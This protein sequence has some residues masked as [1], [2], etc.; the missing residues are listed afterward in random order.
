MKKLYF[1]L[2]IC[3][4][5]LTA[6]ADHI[7]GGDMYYSYVGTVNGLHQYSVT[8]RLYMRC[9]SGRNFND[10]T[11]VS[12]FERGTNKRERDMYVKVSKVENIKLPSNSDPCVTNPPFVC[13]EVGYYIF[14]V[15]LPSSANGY[16]LASQVNYRIAGINNL[17]PGYGLIGATYTTEIPGL[18]QAA[19]GPQNNSANFIGTD[20]VMVCAEN[21]FSYSFAAVDKDNDELRYSFCGAYV[22]GNSNTVSA[23]PPPP[24]QMV[25]YGS[26]YSESTPLGSEV[27]IDPNTGMITGI[28]PRAGVY[29]VTVCVQEIRNGSVISTQRKDL[30][31]FIAPCTIAAAALPTDYMLCRDS[32]S[33]QISNGSTSPLIKSYHW[34]IINSAGSTLY[35]SVSP[36]LTYTFADTGT[37]HVNLYINQGEQC[38]DSAST[39]VLVYPG[40]IPAFDFR[41]VCFTKPTNFTDKTTTIFGKIE[42]WKWDFGESTSS[43]DISS[44]QNAVYTYPSQGNKQAQLIVTNSLGCRDT[45]IRNVPILDKPPILL[46]FSDTL[47]C[48]N[49]SVMLIANGGGVFQWTP[50]VN[51]INP[52]SSTPI[53][54]PKITTSYKV[55]LNDN[56]CLNTDSVIVR[57]VDHV[58]LQ[59]MKDTIICSGD[60]SRLH[61]SSDAL[62][63]SWAP[64]AAFLDPTLANAVCITNA[65]TRYTVTASIGSCVTTGDVTVSTVPYPIADAGKDTVICYGTKGQLKGLTNA[66]SYNWSPSTTV[67]GFATLNP[68]V[69]PKNTTAYVLSAYENFGC[70]KAGT[71]TMI[72][73]VREEIL[74]FA[75]RDTA[76]IVG[77]P[78]QFKAT[79]GVQYQWQP[80]VHLSSSNVS[81]PIG[82]FTDESDRIRYSVFVFDEK[83]CFDSASI[84]INIYKTLP[85]VFVPNA[86]TPNNDK[87]NDLLRPI[88]AGIEKIEYFSVYNRWGQL[89]FSTTING[90]GWDGKINGQEQGAQTYIWV[91]KAVDFKGQPYFQKGM[92]NLIR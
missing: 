77:Q 35:N 19:N 1:I 44:L 53:V 71:D 84:L 56:G 89:V 76:I 64:A 79:G 11:I 7:T 67:S 18:S 38:S 87:L 12:I 23:T 22:S 90:K 51:I 60:Q 45:V 39:L 8:L 20:L 3:T 16:I 34:Q 37:Y 68:I 65:T 43:N 28:A 24:F 85:S 27:K 52:N 42:S 61:V 91:V 74:A 81:N 88:A 78:L 32:K 29:V 54:S 59:A 73:T 47:I 75:G 2:L 14:D 17:A 46:A 92:V 21:P 5:S 80:A 72:M 48:I 82:V 30:Q 6:E 4:V 33:L 31:I 10:P 13:Y 36:S 63:Y 49:D 55:Q 86:F 83:G 50:S 15:F 69:A 57:V 9:N 62:R 25:P 40:L 66:S 26:G 41:G 70:P 58:T